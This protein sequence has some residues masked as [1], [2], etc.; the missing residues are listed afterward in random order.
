MTR[1]FSE[2]F[3]QITAAAIPFVEKRRKA[4]GGFG[5]TPRLPA[6]IEDTFY[7]LH[8]LLL[9]RSIGVP[10][11]GPEPEA[12]P[13]LHAWLDNAR[14]TLQPGLRTIFHLLSSCRLAGLAPA[15]DSLLAAVLARLRAGATLPD[16]YD[17]VRIVAGFFSPQPRSLLDDSTLAGI[18][19]LPWHTV[20][21][22]LMRLT[23]ARALEEPDLAPADLPDWLRACQNGDGGFGF[24]PGTTSFIENCRYCLQAMHLLGVVPRDPVGARRFLARC[25]T[26]AGGFSR[27]GLAAPFLD[28]TWAGLESL[29]L[30]GAE[31]KKA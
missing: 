1:D 28:A 13:G 24:L 5:A 29:R 10:T 15:G 8:I 3:K 21:E 20:D 17:G 22:A 14:R 12:D 11:P 9:A 4:A 18:R 23:L 25:Q 2:D 27:N 6:T 19:R 31:G 7:A 16:W 26:G 30:L